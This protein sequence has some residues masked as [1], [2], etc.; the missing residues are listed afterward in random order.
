MLRLL[1]LYRAGRMALPETMG[2]NFSKL[3]WLIEQY[4]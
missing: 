2:Y 3:Y 1:R 4:N